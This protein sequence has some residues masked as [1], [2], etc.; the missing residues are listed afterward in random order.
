MIFFHLPFLFHFHFLH[1]ALLP[2][3][4]SK[5][6]RMILL[7]IVISHNKLHEILTVFQQG[8]IPLTRPNRCKSSILST[9]NSYFLVFL[10][11]VLPCSSYCFPLCF[12]LLCPSVAYYYP[13]FIF[14]VPV[15][16]QPW[17][18]GTALL[19]QASALA[20]TVALSPPHRPAS[21]LVPAVV[22]SLF[23]QT[24]LICMVNGQLL[25]QGLSYFSQRSCSLQIG[26]G[27]LSHR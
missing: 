7:S 17:V 2:Q 3:S 26:L 21:H 12:Q 18:P 25:R 10:F 1:F 24:S 13:V 9:K 23:H 4:N 20:L 5:K 8:K 11:Q 6:R 16:A 27:H 19:L 14:I 22:S 15:L